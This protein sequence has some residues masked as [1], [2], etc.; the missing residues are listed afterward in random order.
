MKGKVNSTV[1]GGINALEKIKG[2]SIDEF[3][4]YNK[5]QSKVQSI[6]T[7]ALKKIEGEKVNLENEMTSKKVEMVNKVE[8]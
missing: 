4:G 2:E 3:S 1:P 7:E 8:D 6:E 5:L